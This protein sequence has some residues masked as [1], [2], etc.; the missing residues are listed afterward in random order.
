MGRYHIGLAIMAGF[1]ASVALAVGF[2]FSP[3]TSTRKL[4][5]MA[6]AV[7]PVAVLLDLRPIDWRRY[8]PLLIILGAAAVLWLIW[9]VLLRR[10][11]TALWLLALGCGAYGA[12]LTTSMDVLNDAPER[13][14]SAALALGLGSGGAALLGASAV[15]GSTG[16]GLGRSDRCACLFPSAQQQ[17]HSRQNGH[18]AGGPAG[19]TL[20]S[21][22]PR[23]C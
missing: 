20:R 18:S 6:L 3:L 12:W 7:I 9:P 4:I 8:A 14:L 19:R 17:S 16:F 5:L 13:A 1:L 10:E 22:R 23:L 15:A 11:G 21:S 2:N